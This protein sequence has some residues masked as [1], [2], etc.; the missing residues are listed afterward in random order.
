[1]LLAAVRRSYSRTGRRLRE[2]WPLPAGAARDAALHEAR[3][4]AK[5]TRYAAEVA[6]PVLGKRARTFVRRITKVQSLLGD[7]QDTVIAR[8]LERRLGIAA[9]QA[10]ENAF[11][12]GLFYERDACMAGDY[13]EQALAAWQAA[14]APRFRRWLHGGS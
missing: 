5:R 12:Y 9:H 11:S 3:K 13:Q 7:Q 2:A 8:Q 10:G 4:A 14:S 6:A 1:V